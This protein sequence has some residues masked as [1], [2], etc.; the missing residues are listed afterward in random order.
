VK[1]TKK[2]TSRQETREARKSKAPVKR[3]VERQV[4]FKWEAPAS[5]R[6]VIFLGKGRGNRKRKT[7]KR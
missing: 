4:P 2:N 1:L 7:R 6:A 5:G 3:E